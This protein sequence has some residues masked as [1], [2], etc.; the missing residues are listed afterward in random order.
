MY[1]VVF[2]TPNMKGEIAEEVIGTLQLATILKQAGITCDILQFFRIGSLSSFTGF[3]DSAMQMLE[4]RAPKIVSFYTRCDS[5]HIDIRLAQCIKERWPEVYVVFGG[6][7]SDITSTETVEQLACVD[8]VCCGE[9][10]TTVY[11]FFSSLLQGS[12]DLTVPGLVY[13]KNGAV[14]KNPR[15]VLIQELDTLP[16]IDYSFFRFIKHDIRSDRVYFPIDVGRGCPFACTYCSTKTFWGRK[17]RLKSPQ[18]ILKEVQAAYDKFGVTRFVFAHDMFTLNRDKVIE[19][20][21]LLRTLDFPVEWKCSARLDC[22]DR[23]LVDIMVDAGMI[24][25]FIGIE[26]GSPRMQKLINKNLKLDNVVETLSYLKEK[27]VSTTASFIHGFPDETEEDLSQTLCLIRELLKLKT[28]DVQ[29]HLCTFLSGTELSERFLPVMTRADQYSDVTGNF[30]VAECEQM[31]EAHP[32]LFLHML[33]YKSDF[34]TRLRHFKLFVRMWRG[35]QPV[36]QYISEKYPPE[37]LID[38]YYDFADANQAFLD[39]V[40]NVEDGKWLKPLMRQDRF[41]ER[42]ADDVNYDLIADYYRLSMIK[43]SPEVEQGRVITD[44]LCFSPAEVKRHPY[45]QDYTRS[46]TLVT[47]KKDENGKIILLYKKAK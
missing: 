16:L 32:D 31:I 45:L 39:S 21:N 42:F 10:E 6:P 27:G 26:T 30:A 33:E 46:F 14:E 22:I 44:A 1:D 20:C 12:P 40:D 17:Y 28:V 24:R 5:Y 4:E 41:V 15:P 37:R 29:T 36:Y 23:E 18:R 7:Q 25:I 47:C 9:G 13:R 19:T 35:M 8:F 11:P 3:L 34:R 38:M 43:C 2:I